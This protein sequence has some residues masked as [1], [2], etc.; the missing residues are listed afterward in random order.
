MDK[1]KN[2][3]ISYY[4]GNVTELIHRYE[5]AD[6]ATLHKRLQKSFP[7]A[8]KLLELGCGSGR[9]ASHMIGIGYDVVPCSE[10][11]NTCRG[12]MFFLMVHPVLIARR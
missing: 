9:D 11:R 7:K 1:K 10:F 2:Q 12:V 6:V 4:S 5:T 8:G 3:T